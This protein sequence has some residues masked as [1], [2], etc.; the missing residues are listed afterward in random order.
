MEEKE[1]ESIWL[2]QVLPLTLT[3]VVFLGLFGILYGLIF[4]LNSL[5]FGTPIIVHL[6]WG[7]ILFGLTIYLKT[8]VDFA[9]F[10]GNLIKTNPGYKSRIAVE[11][12]TAFGNALGTFAIL[13]LWQFF[14]ELDILLA[15][16]VLL[17]SLVLLRL[18]QDS[19]EHAKTNT[20][21][22]SFLNRVSLGLDDVLGK[23]NKTIAPVLK[24]I[25]PHG[26]FIGRGGLGFWGLLGFAFTIP[27]I[28]GMDDFAGYV[29]LFSIVNVFGFA[30]GVL[31]GHMTL[32]A[33]L[34]LS[35]GWT[36]KAVTNPA[37]SF[38]GSIVFIGLAGYGFAEVVRIF[39]H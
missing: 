13:V 9:I 33:F 32:N 36:I 19:L 34:Y 26:S 17:A 29:P 12:G 22:G 5:R 30:T 28:L 39:L 4:G 14:K 8:S 1:R 18:A 37:I 25:V 38:L 27:F 2:R 35:P 31:L 10:I 20:N 11:I 15:L 7:D 23:V 6:R 3:L 16:M 21:P 24:Y